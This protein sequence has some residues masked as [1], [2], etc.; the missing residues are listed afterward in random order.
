MPK[1]KKT[2]ARNPVDRRGIE[3]QEG[4]HENTKGRKGKS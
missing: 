1:A 4:D 2:E 3:A